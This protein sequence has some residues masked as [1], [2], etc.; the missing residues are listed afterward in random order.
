MQCMYFEDTCLHHD[1]RTL[2]DIGLSQGSVIQFCVDGE[3]TTMR[4]HFQDRVI[5]RNRSERCH[6]LD[7]CQDVY[8]VGI[9]FSDVEL[10]SNAQK[11]RK[12][13][14]CHDKNETLRLTLHGIHLDD[15]VQ[16]CFYP[17]LHIHQQADVQIEII[18]YS[19]VLAQ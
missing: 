8:A 10:H 1:L 12:S 14:F 19:T 6:V 16:L 3:I 18:Q 15:A 4:C 5:T 9:K 11:L 17:E 13:G 7:V 2:R